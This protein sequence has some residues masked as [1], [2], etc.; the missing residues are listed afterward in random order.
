MYLTFRNI[1]NLVRLRSLLLNVPDEAFDMGYVKRF[2]D[3]V[4]KEISEK[5]DSVCH[6]AACGVGWGSVFF[7]DQLQNPKTWMEVT[8]QLFLPETPLLQHEAAWYFLFDGYWRGVDNTVEGLRNRIAYYVEH[9]APPPL[10]DY[11]GWEGIGCYADWTA[12]NK[13]EPPLISLTTDQIENLIILHDKLL[14]VPDEQFNMRWYKQND[15]GQ[16]TYFRDSCFTAA[17]GVG[18]ASIFLKERGDV[19][20]SG[21]TCNLLGASENGNCPIYWFLFHS[22]WTACDNTR[23]GLRR[24]IKY[25]IENRSLPRMN[26]SAWKC[27]K[28]FLENNPYCIQSTSAYIR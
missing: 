21:R 3:N 26:N 7:A 19:S 13:V 24:R 23:F 12:L 4:P 20:S 25:L 10:S 6:T 2:A 14:E 22:A 15:S 28:Q 16:S 17:C 11:E 18:W 27:W 9:L 5:I 1:R 8:N